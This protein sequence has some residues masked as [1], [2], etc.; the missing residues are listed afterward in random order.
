MSFRWRARLSN[1]LVFTR[2][3]SARS[4]SPC[5]EA[6][7]GGIQELVA[8]MGMGAVVVPA[9]CRDIRVEIL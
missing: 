1:L 5:A 3:C 6:E 7:T 9:R 4:Q 2:Y 8:L